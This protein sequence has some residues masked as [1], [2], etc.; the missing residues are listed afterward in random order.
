[1]KFIDTAHSPGIKGR[2]FASSGF[3]ARSIREKHTSRLPNPP[4]IKDILLHERGMLLAREGDKHTIYILNL[5]KLADT[6][7]HRFEEGNM[8]MKNDYVQMIVARLVLDRTTKSPILILKDLDR[9]LNLLISIGLYEAQ[10]LATEL[11]EVRM[12]RPMTHHL[13]DDI[14]TK[15]GG[16]VRAVEITDIKEKTY[17]ASIYLSIAGRELTIDARPSDAIAISLKSKCPI[18][19][20]KSVL[21]TSNILRQAQDSKDFILSNLTKQR[22]GEIL[23]SM[24]PEDFK[25]EM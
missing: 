5:S 2:N 6:Q 8:L 15:I 23:E 10:S 21:E 18:Y 3:F 9:K 17:Y 4:I 22:W 25:Y 12:S 7:T 20:A 13:I 14:L 11:G 1:M 24:S 16:S 19:V